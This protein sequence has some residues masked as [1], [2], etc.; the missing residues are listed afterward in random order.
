MLLDLYWKLASHNLK[1]NDES[2]VNTFYFY[3]LRW[4]LNSK[5]LKTPWEFKKEDTKEEKLYIFVTLMAFFPFF[6]QGASHLC[7]AS[8]WPCP[9][10]QTD[11]EASPALGKLRTQREDRCET[12][13]TTQTWGSQLRVHPL[14]SPWVTSWSLFI[15]LPS[16]KLWGPWDPGPGTQDSSVNVSWINRWLLT[17]YLLCSHC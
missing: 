14:L 11:Q 17:L 6:E 3:L 5:Y 2:H 7:F 13:V 1:I 15:V 12:Y 16:S 8:N 10:R 4:L 9:G